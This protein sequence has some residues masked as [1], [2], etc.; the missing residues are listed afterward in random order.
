MNWEKDKIWSAIQA[1]LKFVLVAYLLFVVGKVFGFLAF[2]L[3]AIL[4]I[5]VCNITT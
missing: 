3:L 2:M 5:I 1:A 4:I